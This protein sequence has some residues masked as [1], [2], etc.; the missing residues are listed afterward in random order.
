MLVK[1]IR[2]RV[3]KGKKKVKPKKLRWS[4]TVVKMKGTK[5]EVG[6]NGILDEMTEIVDKILQKT[7]IGNF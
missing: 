6:Q 5:D 3:K 1:F 7:I 4:K 2:E